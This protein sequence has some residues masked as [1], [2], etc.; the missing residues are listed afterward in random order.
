LLDAQ[1]FRAG[2]ALANYQPQAFDWTGDDFE[3]LCEQLVGTDPVDQQLL[4]FYL[5]PVRDRLHEPLE[6]IY[7]DHE[8]PESIA[9][10]SALADF[11]EDEADRL[12]RLLTARRNGHFFIEQDRGEGLM[13]SRAA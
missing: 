11:C 3:F 2:T 8:P 1:R 7:V 10:A 13:M 5:R 6:A 9:A 12:A 4:R